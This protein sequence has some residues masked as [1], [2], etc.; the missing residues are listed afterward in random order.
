MGA[1]KGNKNALGNEGGRPPYYDASKPED[2]ERLNDK[3]KT[4]FDTLKE[5]QPPTVTGLSL[6]LGF[7]TKTTLYEYAKKVEFSNSI[8]RALTSIEQYHEEATAFGDKCTGN[9][10][11]LKNF[12]WRDTTDLTNNGKDLPSNTPAT[13]IFKKYNDNEDGD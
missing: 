4:Y 7:D 9:I 13:I 3:C 8:K 6:H 11:V 1:A 2:I 12:G 10:F 5:N